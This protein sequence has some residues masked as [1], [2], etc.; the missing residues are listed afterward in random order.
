MLMR[1]SAARESLKRLDRG[2]LVGSC[3]GMWKLTT[4]L[5][6]IWRHQPL[7]LAVILQRSLEGSASRLAENL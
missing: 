4:L 2:P 3:T 5:F 6:P 1:G 7:T